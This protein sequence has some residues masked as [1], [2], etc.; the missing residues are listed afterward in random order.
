MAKWRDRRSE[1]AKS[2][3]KAYGTTCR[4][5]K[6]EFEAI[7]PLQSLLERNIERLLCSDESLM[8]KLSSMADDNLG[9]LVLKLIFKYGADGSTGHQIFKQKAHST[10]EVPKDG[11]IFASTMVWV[12]LCAL[13]GDKQN[14]LANSSAAVRVIEWHL[15][16]KPGTGQLRRYIT[17]HY[18]IFRGVPICPPLFSQSSI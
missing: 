6:G 5:Q 14:P 7:V 16:V 10:D 11:N 3:S 1:C 2:D 4:R 8:A 12:R 15:K 18:L 9:R 17:F 13:V